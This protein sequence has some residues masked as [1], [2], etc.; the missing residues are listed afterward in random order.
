[1]AIVG[2]RTEI[3][4]GIYWVGFNEDAIGLQCNPYL[5][6]DHDEAVLFDPGSVLDFEYV[7]ENVKSI[8]PIE[9]INYVVL[10]HQDPDF[11]SS[12]PLFEK[13][14]AQFTVVT[15]WRT[16]T[17]VKYYGIQ[18]KYYIMDVND[19]KLR[20]SSGRELQFVPTPYLHFAGAVV[21]YDKQTKTLLSSDLFGGFSNNGELY[22]S[23]DYIEKVKAFHEHYMP[24]NDILRPVME[25]L[26]LMD[27]R[28][29]AP[30]H[31]SIIRQD[32]P[33]Y[34][35]ALRDLECGTF[36]KSV[37]KNLKESGGYAGISELILKRYATI[38]SR[39]ELVEAISD[40][41]LV[42]KDGTTE[43]EDYSYSGAE[44]WD[45]LFER[46]YLNK[47]LNWLLVIEPLVHKLAKEYEVPLP[48]IYQ[49]QIKSTQQASLLL[50]E[51]VLELK[52]I[53]E[54][55][56]Q[57]IE[58]TQGRILTCPVTSLYN[59]TFFKEYLK[60]ELENNT[61]FQDTSNACLAIIGLDN[62]ASFRYAYGDG[63]ADNLLRAVAYLLKDIES[64]HRM[65]FRLQG[66]QFAYIM[67]HITKEDALIRAET[68]R[69]TIQVSEKF[70]DE[71]TV[72]IGI[73]S[74]DEVEKRE[75]GLAMLRTALSRFRI[76]K[77]KGGN[78]VCSDSQ[79]E[80]REVK[81]KILVV[82]IDSANQ[83]ILK[84]SLENLKYQVVLASDGLEAFDLAE[85][86]LPDLV[87]SEI[88]LPK[89]DGFMLCEKLLQYSATKNISFML[90]SDLKN[91]DSVKRALKLG[92]EHYFKKP[93][94]LHEILGIIQMKVKREDLDDHQF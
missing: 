82:D 48:Q 86:E 11:C 71:A 30:Q 34:I 76:A 74:Q 62:M 73:V 41:D 58:Q 49:S 81:G 33:K 91:E 19:F 87:V 67:P 1:M 50:Q 5:L 66:D 51:E 85:K 92:V 68:I 9:K 42:L 12:V 43:I 15:T 27:I 36:M 3:A 54:R 37:T 56:N 80:S 32:I 18:S 44:L 88:M 78:I 17:L 83:E 53:N 65:L 52:Q 55:L 77:S 79:I 89:I 40:L 47:G 75:R 23:K 39:E 31:G 69:N 2:K 16:Q 60:N 28:M 59:E 26:L 24:S 35:K 93:Y 45:K 94:F 63:E 10:H 64:D 25:L 70:I 22:A 46:I 57:S 6:V 72:S 61:V 21:T 8:I 7:L 20:L 29:I 14:G 38:Y 4:D 13:A 90:L 84:T